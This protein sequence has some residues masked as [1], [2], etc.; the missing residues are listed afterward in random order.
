MFLK[1]V[2]LKI[3]NIDKMFTLGFL[4]DSGKKMA[5]AGFLWYF[6]GKLAKRLIDDNIAEKV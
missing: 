1:K 3:I 6:E 2:K 5:K 4:G